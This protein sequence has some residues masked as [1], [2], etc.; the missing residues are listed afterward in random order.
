MKRHI[1]IGIA[2][3][4]TIC[5]IGIFSGYTIVRS[6]ASAQ[7]LGGD[8]TI[9][10]LDQWKSDGVNIT[11]RTANKPIKIT[12]TYTDLSPLCLG[13]DDVLTTAGCTGGAGGGGS[14]GGTWSTTTSSVAG[15]LINYPNNTTDIV[16][17]GGTSTSTAKAYFDPNI[18]SFVLQ[19]TAIGST[20][21]IV[22]KTTGQC[23]YNTISAAITAGER[24]IFVKDGTYSEKITMAN[25]KT[26][27]RAQSLL[28]IIQCN[29]STQSPCV[30]L[31]D[32]SVIDGFTINETN[33][34]LVGVAISAS[35]HSLT[36]IL[37][38]RVN[39]FA[40]ST[41]YI[42][43][44][45]LTF[46]NTISGNTFFNTGTCWEF[47]G[48]QANA[49]WI[50]N[51]RCRPMS[52]VNGT[53]GAYVVDARG[54]NFV[55]NDVE[56]TT[57]GKLSTG[58]YFDATSRDN[59]VTG[60]W[61]E[62]LGTGVNI[63]TGA[64]NISFVGTTITSHGTDITNN[65]TNSTFI[66]VNRTGTK[67]F[68][69]PSLTIGSLTGIL[70]GT[71]GVVSVA[72]A[73]TDYVAG[74][75]GA[76]TTTLGAGTTGFSFSNS[77]VIF[78]A[79]PSALSG[80]L[81][82]ANG[83]TGTTT[84]PSSQLLYGGGSGVY[85]SVATTSLT[86]TSV[87]VGGS[88]S[89]VGGAGLTV[90]LNL[91]NPNTWTALQQF[92]G[93]ASTTQLSAGR[94]W[95][96]LTA[97]T[98]IDGTGNIVIP[99]GSGLTNT[100]RSD[101][102]ATWAS[103]VLT[104][105]GV[106]C[107]TGGSGIGDPF[108]H[109]AAGQSATTSL[110]LLNG[111]ASTTMFS[112]YN[113]AYFGATAT[114]SFNSVGALTL[115]TALTVAN[116]GT[117]STTAPS[118]QLLYGGGAGAYQSVATGTLST[119][120]ALSFDANP[121]I[122][123]ASRT[124]TLGTVG[125]A[126]GGTGST[127]GVTGQVPY[128]GPTA[129]QS[130]P[131]TTPTI[132]TGLAYSGTWPAG[133]GGVAGNLTATL[134]T[135]IA[136]NEL[137][138]QGSFATAGVLYPNLT[139]GA[140]ATAATS[141][142]AFTGPFNGT[143]ALGALVGGSNS[144]I[145][146]WGLSTT[147]A[148][149]QGQ[150]LYNTTGGNGVASVATTTLIAGTNVS[151]SGG[152]PVILGSSAVTINA[153][154]GGSSDPFTHTTATN[155][156]TTS[157]LG[158]GS[159]TPF[160]Q[161]SVSSATAGNAATSLFAVASDTNATLFNVLGNGNVGVGTTSPG[162]LFSIN[163]IANFT[164]ATTTFVGTGGVNIK[165]GC[166][167]ING[168]CI[169]SGSAGTDASSTVQIFTATGAN[170]YT[171]PANVKYIVIEVQGGGGNGGTDAG[172]PNGGGGGSG[173]YLKKLLPASAVGT[174]ETAT[175]GTVAGNS[176]FTYNSGGTTLTA[177]GGT[178]ASTGTP[179]AGGSCTGGD[180][181]LPGQTG[182]EGGQTNATYNYSGFGADSFFGGGA[183]A[184]KNT[185]AGATANGADAVGYGA[186]GSGSVSATDGNPVGGTGGAG[187]AGIIIVTEYYGTAGSGG[188]G[189]GISDPFTHP[190][191]GQSAT[192]S[193]LILNGQA[194]TT[195]LSAGLAYFGLTA[196][197]TID[198]TGNVVLPSGSNLTITGK[199]DGCATFSSGQL[200]SAGTPCGSGGTSAFEIGTTSDIAISGVSYFTKTGGRTTLGSVATG[201][202]STSGA[203]SF[204]ANPVILGASRTLTLGTVGIANGGT[205]TTTAPSSQ[206]LYGGGA[207][208]Y[209]SV[210][211]SSASCTSGASCSAFTVVGTVA[212]SITATL[213][214]NIIPTELNNA[215]SSNSIPYSNGDASLFKSV[216]T[217]SLA[218]SGPFN[219]ASAIG[220]LVGGSN[221]TLT[222]TG[223]STT[224]A[225][226]QGQLLYNTTGGNGVAS[227]ATSAPSVN[228]PITYTGTLGSFVGG[229]AG[230]F[231]CTNASS[232]VTG[233]LTG[234]DW[235]TFNG[236]LSTY[237]A[238]TH[239]AGSATTSAI[240]IGTTTPWAQLSVS[241]STASAPTTPLFAV[242][243]STNA[244]LFNILGN[245]N[246]FV[247][248]TTNTNISAANPAKFVIDA[249]TGTS[250][251][252]L[253][254]IGNVNDF[255]ETNV[256]NLNSGTAAQACSTATAN[257]G[258]ATTG[259]VAICANNAN[260]WNPQAYNVGGP[261]DTS[262]MGLATGDLFIAQ[263]TA[264]KKTYFLNGGTSTTTNLT[265]VFDGTNV[266]VGTSSP[267][268]TLSI[269]AAAQ[270][271]PYFAIGSSTSE[272]FKI[273][274]PTGASVGPVMSVGSTS[275][276]SEV[277]I[278]AMNGNTL[279]T[280]FAVGSSTAAATTTH[281]QVT[282][283]G[284]VYAPNTTTSGSAQT[285][286][287]C[288][289][290][291]G[292]FIRDTVV[293]LVSALKF[294]KD[295]NDLS[296]KYGLSAVLQM[297]PVT[298]FLK[299]PFGKNDAGEQIGFIAD[300]SEAVVPQLVTHDSSGDVHG[301]NYEQYTAVITKGI[302]DF[303]KEFEALIARVS[304]LEAKLNAQQAQIDTLNQR[305]DALEHETH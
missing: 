18:P 27:L 264:G 122:I 33:A 30:S 253:N 135:T 32:E 166:Y 226:T 107:G 221:T 68:Q 20:T 152:T 266:G 262:I 236:K 289:D 2:V 185:S 116:G 146:W 278:H 125:Y 115:A 36:K 291:N 132:S 164:S 245:G 144:T 39:N 285:G 265:M 272:V 43:G 215:L 231:G 182:E 254:V 46:Y 258:N 147:S 119:S 193:L 145:V 256:K 197:T 176:T 7:G 255:F 5:A 94:A 95:F 171:K 38:N 140:F 277:S 179:G 87:T 234:T 136:P 127:T 246:V 118:S 199:S 282:N 187:K 42:D 78:G 28:T 109:P 17:I 88:G 97:T 67:L 11:Q 184:V 180:F 75:A 65:G 297:K 12:G 161:L 299:D 89:L 100:G 300:W 211:T 295:I 72:T 305:L 304:G 37:N 101:G 60:G 191:A 287:W 155:S 16:T 52:D 113:G 260:F 178:S 44:A 198:G 63:A 303:Y 207:G 247:G 134:G 208:V 66:G 153:T 162:S 117:G 91:A 156:A 40:T 149:T 217:T 230:A 237:D 19:G 194:S 241:T 206:L 148:L 137:V 205:G 21:A 9:S 14:S 159:T 41:Q 284:A 238:W 92:N 1:K 10:T 204:D 218:F 62:A 82:V 242:A 114:S 280:L 274:P 224:S 23:Q 106:A 69:L 124:L 251:E 131:T 269:N 128:Y 96:G 270:T 175:V 105:T 286:Y 252:G 195:Q 50:S 133:L 196:T 90:N 210:A 51:N 86:G 200:N 219:G 192:T 172:S 59:S 85:Q 31:T 239:A 213:G 203:L 225:L 102:C 129:M 259:F 76:A 235:T 271:I 283:T 79:S 53:F 70:K 143:S 244:A 112:A 233:C 35:D 138:G 232:G 181:N 250:E 73:G 227:V 150:L 141:S 279:T 58:Y 98:T 186:G 288:Y 56:G 294:K 157:S 54:L 84:A 173:C 74:G 103:A 8:G 257:N 223:L 24:D 292:Q 240:G 293:C 165:A 281:F 301:F 168:V 142:L 268:A 267:Y 25:T 4:V 64:N 104:S 80:T 48:T 243:S 163:G 139:S 3:T 13:S 111:Q 121:V 229:V 249:G 188:S 61:T 130:V 275:P 160:S 29:G 99:S 169:S 174:T 22:C 15:R 276:F 183:P 167:A 57:T 45:S 55:M 290:G 214:T 170:T 154:G 123:G 49:N 228:A 190:A 302:Q 158:I 83:G 93:N 296:P 273:N 220:A 26:K 108:T 120:G 71:A 77:P 126:N 47:S 209:Q 151:F 212:P 298:Y 201:T 81:V 263:G 222:W 248:T 177:N 6:Q 202:L 34:Q 189:G 216:A 110:V 261:G